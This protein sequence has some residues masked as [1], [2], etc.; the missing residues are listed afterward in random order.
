MKH[1]GKSLSESEEDKEK[2]E[3]ASLAII[4]ENI[5][6]ACFGVEK[7]VKKQFSSKKSPAQEASR[8]YKEALRE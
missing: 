5:V 6:D 1:A 3:L 8:K 2:T 7:Q 4:D